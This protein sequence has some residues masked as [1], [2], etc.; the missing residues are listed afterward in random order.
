MPRISTLGL[1]LRLRLSRKVT[2]SVTAATPTMRAIT[3]PNG[4]WC[5]PA[6]TLLRCR[7]SSRPAKPTTTSSAHAQPTVTGRL[8][9]VMPRMT[10]SSTRTEPPSPIS[11]SVTPCRPRK[12]ASVTTNDGMPSLAR[13][14][15]IASPISAPQSTPPSTPPTTA[16]RDR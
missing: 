8:S 4:A 6:A 3:T 11:L 16:S 9:M 2:P 15:P 5:N 13:S 14:S 10:G 7:S 1:T 12:N